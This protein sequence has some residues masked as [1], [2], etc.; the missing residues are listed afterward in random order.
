M[1]HKGETEETAR[2]ERMMAGAKFDSDKCASTPN[3]RVP[4]P[5]DSD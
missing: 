4:N 3:Q 1:W 2:V 5:T